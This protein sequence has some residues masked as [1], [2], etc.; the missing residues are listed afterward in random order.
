MDVYEIIT[1][2]IIEK[3][4]AGVVPWRKPW[5]HYSSGLPRNG[6]S[7]HEYTGINRLLIHTTDY[8]APDFYTA[9]QVKAIGGTIRKG[10]KGNIVT[11]WKLMQF[12]DP[13]GEI[14]PETGDRTKKIPLLRYYLVFNREQCDGLPPPKDTPTPSAQIDPIDAAEALISQYSDRPQIREGESRAYYQPTD[15]FVN[16]PLKGSFEAPESWYSTL[17]HELTHSTGHTKRLGR[18]ERCRYYLDDERSREELC[19]EMGASFLCGMSGIDQGTIDNSAAYVG[20]WLSVLK[21][22][23]KFLIEAAGA[24]QK[25]V[26]YMLGKVRQAY[27]ESGE[28][29]VPAKP[30]K[31]RRPSK[32]PT[33]PRVIEQLSFN[34]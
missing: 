9:R 3:L 24:A 4:E 29:S 5:T 32:R 2:K 13:S 30:K 25:A 18:L 33:S 27:D 1:S 26:D 28:P 20:S 34:F 19:A 16:M 11:F 17:F 14:D 6:V 23:K 15:D 12:R 21:G 7:G 31:Q 22:D 10:E 8:T